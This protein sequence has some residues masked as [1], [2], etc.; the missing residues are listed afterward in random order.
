[1]TWLWFLLGYVLVMFIMYIV[2][3]YKAYHDSC[4]YRLKETSKF[5]KWYIATE[6]FDFDIVACMFWPISLTMFIIVAI[7]SWL[8]KSIFKLLD[9]IFNRDAEESED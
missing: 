7:I 8:I 1:M 6:D 5:F 4:F 2:C 9:K 3:A